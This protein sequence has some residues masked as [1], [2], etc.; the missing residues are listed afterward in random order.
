VNSKLLELLKLEGPEL[1]AEFEKASLKGR[2]TPQEVAEFREHHFQS[3]IK[4]YF[5]FPYR[6]AKGNVIDSYGLE[7]PSIDC[8][9]INPSHP[10]TINSHGKFSVIFADGVDVAIELKP[11]VSQLTEL[12][13]GLHQLREL[14]KLRRAKTP[15]L[16]ASPQ[17]GVDS[18]MLELS[19]RTPAFIFCTQAK[20]DPMK[21]GREIAAFYQAQSVPTQEQIDYLVINNVGIVANLKSPSMSRTVPKRAGLF[22]EEWRELTIAAFLLYLSAAY[23]STP[24]IAEPVLRRYLTSLRPYALHLV[25]EHH[26]IAP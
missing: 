20:V 17:F 5:P 10:Y 22:F 11:D 3:F 13:R 15:L 23:H 21:T 8:L 16:M 12:H 18:E 9:I 1:A 4:R 26:N 19:M 24:T 25:G 7:S 2:G 14:K 6:T